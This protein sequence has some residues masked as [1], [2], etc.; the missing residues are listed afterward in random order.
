[1]IHSVVISR[2]VTGDK[3]SRRSYILKVIKEHATFIKSAINIEELNE[4]EALT[5]EGEEE[6]A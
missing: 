3:I 6:R 4:E 5:E 2:E 1:M